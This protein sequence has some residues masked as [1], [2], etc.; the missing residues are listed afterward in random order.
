MGDITEMK[1]R[2]TIDLDLTD[3]VIIEMAMIGWGIRHNKDGYDK[4][5]TIKKN[6]TK[7]DMILILLKQA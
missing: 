2:F 7:M 1:K 3:M 4:T 6:I 5:V